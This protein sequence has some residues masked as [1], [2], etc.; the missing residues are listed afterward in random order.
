MAMHESKTGN[1]HY[2]TEG[3]P[4]EVLAAAGS[5][6]VRVECW[7]EAEA[8][9]LRDGLLDDGF[10]SVRIVGLPTRAAGCG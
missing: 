9:A 7:T 8:W 5:L 3:R 1:P 2:G 10:A 6:S 4:F